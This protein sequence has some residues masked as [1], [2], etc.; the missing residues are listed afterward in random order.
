VTAATEWQRFLGQLD[1]HA[2]GLRA[3]VARAEECAR[4]AEAL[5]TES[6]REL[7]GWRAEVQQARGKLAK[8]DDS[9]V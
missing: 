6:A 2:Q 4:R 5:L 9:C 8:L 3:C 1:G 7:E